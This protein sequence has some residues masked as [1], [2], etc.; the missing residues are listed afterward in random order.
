MSDDG[1]E[2]EGDD[3]GNVATSPP[4]T[5]RLRVGG[6]V[7][8][9]RVYPK[10]RKLALAFD[11]FKPLIAEVKCMTGADWDGEAWL[12]TNN[13]RN[14]M[15]LEIL[16]GIR[17]VELAR[18]RCEYPRI[19]FNG[20]WGHQP[21]IAG[22]QEA[23]RRCII[24]GEPG[25]GKTRATQI[26]MQR[27]PAP[28][29]SDWWWCAPT[30]ALAAIRQEFD[31]WGVA[32]PRF[33]SYSE[34]V[35]GLKGFLEA[36]DGGKAPFGVVFD[37]SSRLKNPGTRTYRAAKRVADAVRAEQDGFVIE[38]SGTPAPHDPC[39]LWA[40]AEI[41]CPGYLRESS[42]AHLKRRLAVIDYAAG[43][44]QILDWRRKEIA[45]LHR[46]LE[47]L[48]LVKLAKDCMDL[49][50]L[51]EEIVDL[52][53][54]QEVKRT[55]RLVAMTASGGA[56]ALNKVRQFSD[57]FQYN[58]DGTTTRALCPKDGALQAL[59]ARNEDIGRIVIFADYTESVNRCVDVCLEA[60]W[61]VLRCDGETGWRA[62]PDQS[63]EVLL[64]QFDSD[65]DTKSHPKLAFVGHP[66][67]GGLGLNLTSAVT[68]VFYSIGFN[69]EAFW[70]GKKRVH[71]G[72]QKNPVTIYYLSHL[73][74]DRFS[75]EKM[76]E[77]KELQ[78]IVLGEV[79]HAL[80]D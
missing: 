41:A 45:L 23:R 21:D 58:A 78:D 6:K 43:Y 22:F 5:L 1:G 48:M 13:R 2:E 60:G 38:M 46:R 50:P 15:S 27:N 31:K 12:I 55:A 51:R 62:Y 34:G 29:G 33:L 68:Q 53:V 32:P 65:L 79:I 28:S 30:M 18:Y 42:V 64:R 4:S 69:A 47:G 77:K 72:G 11:Y 75:I 24:A 9:V 36:W 37:E 73:P 54:T 3:A 20:A 57:G 52:P 61:T 66:M 74:T 8:T 49:P 76:E 63:T 26:V 71:R 67:S 80:S 44:P 56:Q 40:Q 39:D 17:P 7:K 10:G 14:Q 70:Q 16:Q 59:L 25:I 35:E 19:E